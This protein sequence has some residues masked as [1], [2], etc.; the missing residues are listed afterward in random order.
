MASL[1]ITVKG[2][3]EV[4]EVAM[5]PSVNWMTDFANKEKLVFS[6][7]LNDGG[8]SYECLFSGTQEQIDNAYKVLY[9]QYYSLKNRMA[10]K[11]V[12]MSMCFDK[13]NDETGC[14]K[15]E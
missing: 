5:K 10:L 6:S 4:I 3:K 1:K 15:V 12:G 13:I 2:K 9:Q 11:M 7:V 8:C 14:K